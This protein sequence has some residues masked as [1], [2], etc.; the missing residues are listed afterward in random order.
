MPVEPGVLP[1][2]DR[3]GFSNQ[4]S[5]CSQHR[6]ICSAAAVAATACSP[7]G[8]VCERLNSRTAAPMGRRST[9]SDGHP[10]A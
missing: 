2:D 10:H 8:R 9:L 5:T 1:I 3:S 4:T 6:S 7:R